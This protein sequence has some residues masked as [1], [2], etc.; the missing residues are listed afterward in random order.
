MTKRKSGKPDE[1]GSDLHVGSD[2]D[3]PPDDDGMVAVVRSNG[4]RAY[5]LP[6]FVERIR[7]DDAQACI[8]D[9][10]R[11]V[12]RIQAE[13]RQLDGLVQEAREVH[14][15]SWNV[16]GWSTGMAAQSARERWMDDATRGKS[17]DH[18]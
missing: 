15:L 10:Q 14:G 11:S 6:R 18:G 5:F 13:R 17:S 1:L 2:A 4:G 3:A 7:G 16:I 12:M 9:L 8:A